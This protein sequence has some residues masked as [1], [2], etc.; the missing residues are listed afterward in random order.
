MSCGTEFKPQALPVTGQIP[1][2]PFEESIAMENYQTFLFF[3]PNLTKD[4]ACSICLVVL[5]RRK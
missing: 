2:L 1:T 5:C 3:R 4:A